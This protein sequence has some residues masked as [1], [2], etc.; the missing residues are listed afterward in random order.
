MRNILCVGTEWFSKNGGLST[1]NRILCESLARRS[2]VFCYVP[3]FSQDEADDAKEKNVIL[4]KPKKIAGISGISSLSN[5]PL[6]SHDA[7]I[8][9]IVGHDRITGPFMQAIADNYFKKSIK[10]LFIHTAPG[11]LEWL[12]PERT[13]NN[14]AERA[15]ERETIQKDL[16]KDCSVVAA[17]GPKLFLEIQT[18]MAGLA[19]R[20][21]IIRFD[22]G[23]YKSANDIDYS[24]IS[25][26]P[27][28]LIIGRLDDFHLKGVDIA[29]KAMDVVNKEWTTK[30]NGIVFKPRLLI[31]GASIGSEG[32][33]LEKLNSLLPETNLQFIIRNYSSDLSVITEEI[34]RVGV[35]LMPSRSEGFGLVGL[36]AMSYGRPI[37]MSENSGLGMLIQEI[38][39]EEAAKWVIN[40]DTAN[41]GV[42][43]WASRIT[44]ILLDKKIAGLELKKLNELYEHK[45]SWENSVDRLMEYVEKTMTVANEDQC[46]SKVIVV[47]EG[48]VSDGSQT[49]QTQ[50]IKIILQMEAGSKLVSAFLSLPYTKRFSIAKE[51]GL[52]EEG[53]TLDSASLDKLSSK[54]LERAFHK[55]KLDQLWAKIF[56]DS[57]DS[58]PF[59]NI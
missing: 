3:D 16:A 39:P 9:V 7:Q 41:N 20:P 13:H 51:L 10:V 55:K 23:L 40:R 17:V 4:V 50:G 59:K 58:N 42:G 5:R 18:S 12:K 11:E 25:P 57:L 14:V 15:E 32:Q 2:R 44:N 19:T 36:E 31:R 38:A 28:S 30:T 48:V 43:I 33:M 46:C 27:E 45:V 47:E 8:D 56:N 37:L 1:F 6:L 29:A 24:S 53:E 34:R 54:F 52:L 22:P 35:L 21:D 49:N 26:I